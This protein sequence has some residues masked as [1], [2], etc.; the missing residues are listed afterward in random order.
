MVKHTAAPHHEI[1]EAA[2]AG[3]EAQRQKLDEK[4]A[5]VRSMLGGRAGKV[6]KAPTWA[7]EATGSNGSAEEAHLEPRGSPANCSRAK[8]ALGGVSSEQR[9]ETEQRGS[10]PFGGILD[11]CCNSGGDFESS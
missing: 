5:Q 8:E 4:I 6:A 2:L 7:S 11:L 3:F 1:L 9:L 10:R